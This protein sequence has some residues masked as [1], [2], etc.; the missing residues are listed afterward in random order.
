MQIAEYVRGRQRIVEHV[1][2]AHT[3]AELGVLLERARELLDN[4][5]QGVLDLGVEP[6][7]SVKGL[8]A[9]V[10]EPGLFAVP[11]TAI[12][13]G[14]DG[15]GRVVGTDSRILFDGL[16]GVF[17]ALGFDGLEDE[18]FRD[19]VIA[20]VVE[21]TSLLDAGRVLRDL[22]RSAA[23][24]ATMK[25]TLGRAAAGKYRDRIAT[26]C[27]QHASTSGDISLVLYDVTTLYFEA[28]KEDELRKVGYSKERRVD[29]QIVVGL[30]VDRGG[31]PLEIGCFEGNKA[32]T[33]T[34]IPIIKQFQARHQLADMVVV[35]DAGMLGRQ[36]ART[37]RS[38]PAVH[39]RVPDDEGTDRPGLALPLARRCV[40]RRAA[41]RH[42][43]AQNRSHEGEQPRP[44][45]RIRLGPRHTSG[46]LAGGM[47]LLP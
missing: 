7:P 8:V 22:G 2:S 11:D 47:G 36:P 9:P 24:Y 3:E 40:H 43:H 23:S 38:E 29:P 1:G 16:A 13:A 21:P 27:F 14:R 18:V 6:T 12:S 20:R 39:R 35:A 44:S 32:E 26:W 5:A 19:L 25:R 28:E 45:R 4:P 17:T 46:F 10:G 42:D 31:F 30:L 15:P 37:G 33:A 34:M 41:D